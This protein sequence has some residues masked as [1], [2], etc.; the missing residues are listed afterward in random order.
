MKKKGFIIMAACALGTFPGAQAQ[1]I[2]LLCGQVDDGTDRVAGDI[3]TRKP[4]DA[5]VVCGMGKKVIYVNEEVTTHIIMPENIK[6]VDISTKKIAGNQYADNIVRIKPVGKMPDNELAGTVTIIGERNMVQY[7][8]LYSAYPT[9]AF[10]LY[11][12]PHGELDRYSNP[13]VSMTEGE[14]ARFCHAIYNSPRKFYGIRTSKYGIRAAV[15]N[16]YTLNDYFFIEFSLRNKTRIKYDIDEIRV[17]LTDKKQ[18]KATNSQTVELTPVWMLNKA[19]TL[20]RSYRN[21]LVIDKLTFPNEKVLKLEICEKQISGRV[22][23]I[24]IDYSDILNAD[25][26]DD[27]LIHKTWQ[28]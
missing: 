23:E 11:K 17:K 4:E 2:H 20:R 27:S 9:R 15:S 26:F 5:G 22:I 25:G 3:I 1:D 19:K 16:I 12:V 18:S 24:P 8:I 21:V 13:G 7:D 28:P 6:L 10:S 14:M